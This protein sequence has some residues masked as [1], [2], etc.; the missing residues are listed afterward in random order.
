M[1]T[2]GP[3]TASSAGRKSRPSDGSDAEDAEETGADAL[4]FETLGDRVAGQRG[5]PRLE[6]GHRLEGAAALEEFAISAI[7]EL[8][9]SA[10]PG[11]P[12]HQD[13]VWMRIRQRRKENGIHGA[14]DG[15]AG[16]DAEGESDDADDREAAMRAQLARGIA[17]V[18][19]ECA[20]GVFPS[21]GT[22]LFLHGVRDCRSRARA[23]RWASSGLRPRAMPAAIASSR[24]WRI[25]A[26]M[27]SLVRAW[28]NRPR[29]P[30]RKLPPERHGSD[31]RFQQAC[32]GARATVPVGS[33]R[34]QAASCLRV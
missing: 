24:Y 9:A 18:E 8:E 13:A 12:D 26:A 5:L 34:V 25:S 14:E 4:A 6:D 21:V 32:D 22:H 15:R 28:R 19:E 3:C 29:Q 33:F 10:A 30:A 20:D 2:R 23:A 1:A 17:Q 7:G 11:V 16:A 27:S 31:L